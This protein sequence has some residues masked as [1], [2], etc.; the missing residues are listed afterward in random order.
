MS[1]SKRAKIFM[2]L[3]LFLGIALSVSTAKAGVVAVGPG[4]FGAGS[5]LI[6]FTGLPDGTEVNGLNF[7][8]VTFSY[9]LGNGHVVI[10]GGP[11]TTN[12]VAP[13]NIV[14]IGNNTGILTINLGG[15]AN[16]FGYG[17]AVLNT[18]PLANATT[19]NLFN[20]LT[21][22]GT[23][24]YNGVPDPNFTGGFAGIFS[25]LP[26]NRVELT[27]ISGATPAF[28]VD[29]IRIANTTIPEPMTML[30]LGTGLAGI[31]VKVRKRRKTV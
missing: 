18:V 26:F 1:T 11:G 8:G 10:D 23:L 20:G 16:T 9:S 29:N 4:A 15:L 14:S 31:V 24:S 22:V 5:T 12:N 13:P 6:T 28:A 19:I 7:G 25:T 2:A 3:S 27:F 21:N 17:Y 30:L